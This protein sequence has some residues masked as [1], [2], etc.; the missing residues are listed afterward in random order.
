M[1]SSTRRVSIPKSIEI[2][3]RSVFNYSSPFSIK[4]LLK[5]SSFDSNIHLILSWLHL[6]AMIA[7]MKVSSLLEIVATLFR[8]LFSEPP[9]AI[10]VFCTLL[11]RLSSSDTLL[12]SWSFVWYKT[13]FF[14]FRFHSH[15]RFHRDFLNRMYRWQVCF[16]S[17]L[18]YNQSRLRSHCYFCISSCF[19][20][21]LIIASHRRKLHKNEL[22]TY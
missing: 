10:F 1:I 11:F 16:V 3:L 2:S 22:W 21:F 17:S 14:D 4:S 15:S 8:V 20:S 6:R 18:V 12:F 5:L 9:E 19:D 7:L 13:V